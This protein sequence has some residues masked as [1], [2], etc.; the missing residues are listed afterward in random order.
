MRRKR[1]EDVVAASDDKKEYDPIWVRARR[2]SDGRE[3]SL[4]II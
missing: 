1:S 4:F 2:H 3:R